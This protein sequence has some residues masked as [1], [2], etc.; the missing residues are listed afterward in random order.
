M[1]RG[2]TP[3]PVPMSYVIRELAKGWNLPPWVVYHH[4]GVD[5]ITQE[6]RFRA[7]EASVQ[8][9]PAPSTNPNAPHPTIR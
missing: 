6:L 9:R 4:V 1:K 7:I 2:G 3:G 8:D 5:E